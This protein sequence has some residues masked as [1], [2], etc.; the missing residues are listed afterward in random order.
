MIE[1]S[2]HSHPNCI[3]EVS[4]KYWK[5]TDLKLVCDDEKVA[6]II[7]EDC[8]FCRRWRVR[9]EERMMEDDNEQR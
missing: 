6:A 2:F 8:P 3:C 1:A 7:T 4:D 9:V 5:R